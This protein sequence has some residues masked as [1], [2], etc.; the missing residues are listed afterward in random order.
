MKKSHRVVKMI[1]LI[2][3]NTKKEEDQKFFYKFLARK[4]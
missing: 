1:E 3:E 4:K 2:N